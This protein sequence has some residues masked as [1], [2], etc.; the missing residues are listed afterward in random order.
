MSELDSYAVFLFLIVG[1]AFYLG[2]RYAEYRIVK[3]MLDSMTPDERDRVMKLAEKSDDELKDGD[4]CYDVAL[5]EI[6]KYSNTWCD[7]AKAYSK[8]IIATTDELKLKDISR[9]LGVYQILP[10]P[11]ESFIKAYIEAY[12]NGNVIEDI[13]IEVEEIKGD[14]G[15]I[16]SLTN[17]DFKL[18]LKDNNIIIKK[19][20]E[21]LTREE[22]IELIK[23]AVA[24]SLDWSKANDN[25]HSFA[26]IE[27]RFLNKWI[28][29]T[30]T[31]TIAHI[32]ELFLSTELFNANYDTTLEILKGMRE[33]VKPYEE[34][35]KSKVGF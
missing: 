26:I 8:K 30:D 29:D 21:N 22:A 12:N 25:I 35:G 7:I 10:S 18:K 20:K 31:L 3:Q 24:E 15:I 14:L 1:A 6:D 34:A 33:T 13:L 19:V 9:P 16:L 4:W 2:M 27:G 23:D 32:K 5:K 11:S 28:E 17:E